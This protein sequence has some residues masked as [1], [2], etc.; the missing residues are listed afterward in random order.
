MPSRRLPDTDVGRLQALQTASD[1]A[2]TV[3]AG[4]LAFSAAT[5]TRLDTTLPQFRTEVGERGV[6]L[7]WN[8]SAN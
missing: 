6:A 1:K 4:Q 5:K 8:T 2:A 7:A 3:P